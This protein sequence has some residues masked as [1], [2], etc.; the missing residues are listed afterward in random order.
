MSRKHGKHKL[1]AYSRA[2][3]RPPTPG[4]P[5]P[6]D[7]SRAPDAPAGVA[8]ARLAA[9]FLLV[10][11]AAGPA[12]MLAWGRIGSAA[13]T[14]DG[15]SAA[16][17]PGDAGGA[18]SA[19]AAEAA[20]SPSTQAGD[21]LPAGGTTWAVELSQ[22]QQA[23]LLKTFM[24]SLGPSPGGQAAAGGQQPE[25]EPGSALPA[26]RAPVFVTVYAP[27]APPVR[28][29]G[30]AADLV[31][32][33]QEAA[34]EVASRSGGALDRDSLRLRMDVLTEARPFPVDKRLA[35]ARMDFGEPTGLALRS[36][37]DFF[38]LPAD[39]V[40]NPTGTNEGM[41]AMLCRQAGLEPGAWQRAELP[42]WRLTGLSFV[43]SAPGSTYALACPRG[44][45]AP[46]EPTV[47]R[48]L[49]AC[50]LAAH[51]LV[52]VQKEEG[53]YL[54]YW[55]VT[56]GL[57]GG[58]DSVPEQAAA[59]GALGAF[60]ELRPREEGL[61]SCYEALSYL[62]QFT[63]TDKDNPKIAFTRRQ[64]VC[65][66]VWEL[67]A[68]AHVLEAMCRYRRAGALTEPDPWIAGLAEFLLFMQRDD[69]SFELRYDPETRARTT[70]RA[71]V[72]AV[73]PQAKAAVAL[74]LAYRELEVPRYLDGAQRALAQLLAQDRLRKEP[75]DAHEARWLI[76]AVRQVGVLA[77]SEEYASWGARIA[78][79]R[80]RFQLAEGDARAADVVGGT[81]AGLPPRAGTTADDLVVFAS[82]CMMDPLGG[83]E[84]LLAARRAAAY[85]MQ[86]QYLPENAYYL[87]DP[88][89]G[90][91]GFREQPGSN[92]IRVQ[93]VESALRGLVA[94]AQW[95]LLSV[96]GHD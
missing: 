88:T 27:K 73:A 45:L 91:G 46:G 43:N 75:Y 28:S 6:A 60:C 63:D 50:R 74:A 38:L 18:G 44:L 4:A 49:R 59:V 84:N 39:G 11:M 3:S 35:F 29:V 89:A 61:K 41:L 9:L 20:P 14:A 47:A 77:P 65:G 16:A 51:Y 62:M 69:G 86:L 64:E 8:Q 31:Q 21:V 80:R 36:N 42:M 71:G 30:Y 12:L 96:Q 2:E 85:I 53:A 55:S 26:A 7:N 56:S 54:T 17:P 48:L 13:R 1:R 23:R 22:G 37:G 78:A 92:I 79:A 32:S 76:S 25:G 90:L 82:A 95:E 33:V 10:L 34:W 72:G 67:E 52:S 57:R 87:S 24:D 94:L 66:V 15:P 93:T 19:Q 5:E 58:C 83:Q 81:L 70:P 40:D 68:S